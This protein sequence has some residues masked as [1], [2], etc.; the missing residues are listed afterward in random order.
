[1]K[2]NS[3]ILASITILLMIISSNFIAISQ[4][5]NFEELLLEECSEEVKLSLLRVEHYLEIYSEED[6]NVFNIFYACPPRYGYQAPIFVEIFNDTDADIIN[7]KIENNT[8][9]TPNKFVNFTINKMSKNEQ[10]LI[11]FTVWMLVEHND[12]SDMPSSKNFPD[13]ANLPNETKIWLEKT[14][15]T[16]KDNIFIKFRSKILRL[17][18]DDMISYAKK[19]A[20]F[21]KNHRYLLFLLQLK[22]G[23]FFSQDAVTTLLIN[24]ENVGR[25]HLACALFRNQNVPARVILVNNDQGFW[26]QMHYMVE[27]YVPDYGWVLL[28]TTKGQTPY[29]T[30]RQVINRICYPSDENDTKTDYIFRFMK[31]EE[32]WIWISDENVSPIYIDCKDAS[33]SQMFK[34]GKLKTCKQVSLACFNST[35]KVFDKYQKYQGVN[36]TG[37]N[38]SFFENAKELQ[39]NA[40]NSFIGK[41]ILNYYYYLK[42]SLEEYNKITF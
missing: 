37:E 6:T 34:E 23:V 16:Q 25:S 15:V 32:R 20:S 33:K 22:L 26:T 19:V 38:I 41:D 42:R 13:T 17:G 2:K 29:N 39:K 21:I 36:L 14:D 10:K 8:N 30:S 12:F 7:Y 24:G 35:E 4:K 31:G 9:C 11:H 27:Y 40:I 3:K 28:D 1:M 18:T 5:T